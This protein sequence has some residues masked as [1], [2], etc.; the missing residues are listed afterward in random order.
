MD[1]AVVLE[2]RI[3]VARR[4]STVLYLRRV[5]DFVVE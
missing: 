5:A 4:M 3:V 2:Y 1:S